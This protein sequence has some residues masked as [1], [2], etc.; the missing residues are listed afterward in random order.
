MTGVTGPRGTALLLAAAG[1]FAGWL[2]SGEADWVV[3]AVLVSPA[4]VLLAG[5]ALRRSGRRGDQVS[6]PRR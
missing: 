5:A 2:W 3:G 1:V 6:R 4:V